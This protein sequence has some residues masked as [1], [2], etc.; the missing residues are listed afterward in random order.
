MKKYMRLSHLM[1]IALLGLVSV[2]PAAIAEET[3]GEF[4][5][6]A[7]VTA[8]V[9]T[10]LLRDAR[11]SGTAIDVETDKGTVQLSGVVKSEAERERALLLAQTVTGVKDVKDDLIIQ[12]DAAP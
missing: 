6:D 10:V 12:T 9:K 4:I 2:H 7:A 5:D 3:L 11:V 8:K 1:L